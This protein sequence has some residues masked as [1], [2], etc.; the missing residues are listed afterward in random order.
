MRSE[1]ARLEGAGT[2]FEDRALCD[3]VNFVLEM[4]RSLARGSDGVVTAATVATRCG[5][6]V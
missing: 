1:G 4:V 2:V 5:F 3:L 6:G